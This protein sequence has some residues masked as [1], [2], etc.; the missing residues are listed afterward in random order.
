[1]LISGNNVLISG[2]H[3]ADFLFLEIGYPLHNGFFGRNIGGIDF[4]VFNFADN[5]AG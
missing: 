5:Q 2:S 3:L 1:M 4:I